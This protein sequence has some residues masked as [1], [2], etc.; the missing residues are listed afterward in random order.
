MWAL[1]RWLRLHR[2]RDFD[3]EGRD[4]LRRLVGP[5]PR[6]EH[7]EQRLRGL[8]RAFEAVSR[9]YGLAARRRRT[10]PWGK[11]V[12][13]AAIGAGLAALFSSALPSLTAPT[14]I[15][16]SA[17]AGQIVGYARVIDGDTLDVDR[18]RVRLHGIDAPER[19]QQCRREGSSVAVLY[20]CGQDATAALK[21][22]I[23]SGTVACDPRDHDRYG[24]TIAVCTARG[25]DI[26]REMVRQGW[27]VA[28]TRFSNDYASDE[29]AA[30]AAKRALW[31]GQFEM[32]EEW[33]WRHRGR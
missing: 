30:R 1:P 5:P 13:F 20:S 19:D 8:K 25:S 32:P 14:F 26:A 17:A 4:W 16:T 28:Y 6:P 7:P 9:S 15:A 29:V 12:A 2:T 11:L 31:A 21:R 27:A 3:Q 24:R 10:V 22:I 23:G 18:T 33:R